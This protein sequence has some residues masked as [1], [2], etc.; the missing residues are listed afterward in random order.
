[1]RNRNFLSAILMAIAM[2][3][4]V[5]PCSAK[6]RSTMI[7]AA[8][9]D[10]CAAPSNYVRQ[11]IARIKALQAPAPH[12]SNSNLFDMLGGH[13]D[14]DAEKAVEISNLRYEA[15]GVNALLSAGGCK[16]FDLDHE[17]SGSGK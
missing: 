11:R 13:Q 12:S 10:P 2:L 3:C 9:E 7:A 17:L 16:A 8:N 6:H 14:S 5:R 4:V 1:M 15:D